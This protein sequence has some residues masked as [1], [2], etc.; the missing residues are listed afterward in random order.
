MEI[1]DISLAEVE[2]ALDKLQLLE[3]AELAAVVME[4]MM[5][6]LLKREL[7][8]LEVAAEAGTIPML[9]Q[10]AAQA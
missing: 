6:L 1:V 8:T 7:L 9:E 4:A 2:A 5:E 3:L 10:Q